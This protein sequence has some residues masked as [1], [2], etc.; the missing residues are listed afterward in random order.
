MGRKDRLAGREEDGSDPS[1]AGVT[2]VFIHIPKTGG[3]GLKAMF[4][5]LEDKGHTVPPPAAHGLNLQRMEKR[6][7]SARASFILRDPIERACSAFKSRLRVGLQPWSTEEAIT[8]SFFSQPD[9]WLKAIASDDG[10]LQSAA[11]FAYT[12]N[13]LLSRNYPF[14]FGSAEAARAAA[15]RIDLVGEIERTDDFIKAMLSRVAPEVTDFSDIYEPMYVSPI[16]TVEV[17]SGLST[18]EMQKVRAFFAP[19]YEIYDYL[20]TLVNC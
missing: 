19:E 2:S 5:R 9:D 7:P 13:L 8:Y 16:S 14:Y 1:D 11:I 4:A 12:T 15:G 6:Y 18:A 10:R 17:V 3:T 20:K